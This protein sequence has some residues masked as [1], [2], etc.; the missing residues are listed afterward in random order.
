M[1]TQDFQYEMFGSKHF[2]LDKFD[3]SINKLLNKIRKLSN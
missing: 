3:T 2:F 1:I